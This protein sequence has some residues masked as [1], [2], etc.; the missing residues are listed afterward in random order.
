MIRITVALTG[1]LAALAFSAATAHAHTD[2]DY[3]TPIGDGFN[4][5]DCCV[6]GPWGALETQ[7]FQDFS[8]PN[9]PAD[10]F[11]GLVREDSPFF[12]YSG[13]ASDNNV[14]VEQDITGNVPI[15]EQYNSLNFGGP[16]SPSLDG[17]HLIYNDIGVTPEAFLSTPFGDLNFPT[18]F[19]EAVGPSLFEPSFYTEPPLSG[20]TMAAAELPAL[21]FSA[22]TAHA[23]Y[24][25]DP[26][27]PI[28]FGPSFDE[29]SG[30]DLW[31][32][33]GQLSTDYSVLNHPDET[34]VGVERL[35]Y[36]AFGFS[37]TN[38]YVAQ[39]ISGNVPVGEQYNDF[40][41]GDFWGEVYNDIGGTPEAFYITPF[42]DLNVPTSLV[43]ALGPS[44]FE[45]SMFAEAPVSA[46]TL[47]AE[48]PGLAA[49]VPSLLAGLW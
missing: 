16:T 38:I 27:G 29:T 13:I 48:L 20:A 23:D 17:F 22:A 4:Y 11:E 42:G 33:H 18:W 12:G 43:E 10:T 19:V 15:G 14:Y 36:D 5:T 44:F 34:F 35:Y 30:G 45:A 49:D 9:D 6:T 31:S 39:D 37:E 28:P 3:P 24:V 41:I 2:Y 7:Y 8:V 32:A 26:D 40:M 1:A 46:A 21:A 25:Y 47:S